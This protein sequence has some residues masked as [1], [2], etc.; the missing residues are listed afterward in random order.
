MQDMQKSLFL[1]IARAST[2]YDGPL[3]ILDFSSKVMSGFALCVLQESCFVNSSDEKSL[4]Y[5]ASC[6]VTSIEGTCDILQ[7]LITQED[8]FLGPQ[9]QTCDFFYSPDARQCI[10][11]LSRSCS[12]LCLI[13][14]VA[15]YN[16]CDEHSASS[17]L[18]QNIILLGDYGTT[19]AANKVSRILP[20]LVASK[21]L[22]PEGD[23]CFR[24]ALALMRS[25]IA[26]STLHCQMKPDHCSN[27]DCD[28]E[29]SSSLE[30]FNQ[31]TD[32]D[33]LNIDIDCMISNASARRSFNAQGSQSLSIARQ[34]CEPTGVTS[35]DHLW[36]FLEHS[37]ILSKVSL[38]T[39]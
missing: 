13:L 37:L 1:G 9:K 18:A 30:A 34:R 39:A 35:I 10:K 31:I 32:D 17:Q 26:L 11:V 36:Y 2:L 28:G 4:V 33:L 29:G 15:R 8:I 24:S 23:I 21:N 22:G 27:L 6:I 20:L 19:V 16:R 7:S 14:T 5:V 38:C 3:P 25:A 12:L